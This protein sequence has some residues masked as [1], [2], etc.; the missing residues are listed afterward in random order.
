[1]HP[2]F[3]H[4]LVPGLATAL[5][6]Q[7][8][9]VLAQTPAVLAG[10]VCPAVN[11]SL[12]LAD[13]QRLAHDNNPTLSAARHEL[14]ATDG[15]LQQAGAWPNP[16]FSM[17]LEDTK[18][19]T[20]TTT[21]TLSQTLELGGKRGARVAAARLGQ[22]AARS[23][24]VAREAGLRADVAQAWFEV[25]HSRQRLA[26]ALQSADLAERMSDTTG[27]RVQAG[28]LSPVEQTRSRV[29]A[30]SARLEVNQAESDARISGHKLATLLGRTS[31]CVGEAQ[32]DG[33]VLPPLPQIADVVR[34]AA[35]APSVRL[36][37]I[38]V[39]RNK[40]LADIES[41]KRIPDLT[42]SLGNKRDEEAARNMTVI[43]VSLPLPL[44]DRNQGNLLEALRRTDRARDELVAAELQAQSTAAEGYET[45]RNARAEA[46]ALQQDVL[47]AAQ[48]AYAAAARGF[49]LGKFGFT[50]VLDAQR[51]LF[52]TQTQYLRALSAAH[53]AAASLEAL[54]GTELARLPGA[55]Q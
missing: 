54:L 52:Q 44:F 35:A 48:Q 30:S 4:V 41:S 29:A 26:L 10:A 7:A 19:A 17:E 39:D 53:R 36:A 38:E 33:A 40:A 1:M 23:Q 55:G 20:R 21:Y 37:G 22:D 9:P 15:A 6:L 16:T 31:P 27:R 2:M 5:L 46:Q 14:A 32:G 42:V 25:L 47:P 18:K 28:K 50:E 51:T 34:L 49:E 13:A 45:L 43:G 24:L 3:Q 12:T 8:A 11:P